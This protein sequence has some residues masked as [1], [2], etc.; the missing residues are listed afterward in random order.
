MEEIPGIP[1]YTSLAV[2]DALP[3]LV[4]APIDRLQ[5]ALY[6]G[7]SSDYNP[8]HLDEET[9]R[10]GGL[11]GVIA[12]GMLNMA[13]LGQLLT[14]W[15]PQSCLRNFSARFVAMTFPGDSVTCRG[16][17][18]GKREEGGERLVDLEL[19]A[20]TDDGRQVLAGSAC[21]ALP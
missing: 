19:T 15:A 14:G 5:L 9:A 6:A 11:P 20:V 18:T 8:I 13:F 10:A 12:H 17:V 7:A 4:K 2:G 21:I 3:D 16:T 1:E